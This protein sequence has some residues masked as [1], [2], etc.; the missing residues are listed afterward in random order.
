MEAGILEKYKDY[1]FTTDMESYNSERESCK[2]RLFKE[3]R[4]QRR[5]DHIIGSSVILK[6]QWTFRLASLGIVVKYV[7]YI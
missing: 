3:Y 1:S 2:S 7:A 6:R 4:I 5:N